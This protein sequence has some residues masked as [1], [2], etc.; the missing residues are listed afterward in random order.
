LEQIGGWKT[1]W[2]D[3]RKGWVDERRT[4]ERKDIEG[5]KARRRNGWDDE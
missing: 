2:M 5:R 4:G 1:G 3:G